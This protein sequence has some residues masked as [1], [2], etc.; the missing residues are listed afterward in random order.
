MTTDYL[1]GRVEAVQA[2]YF[3]SIHLLSVFD[4]RPVWSPKYGWLLV[5]AKKN[6]LYSAAGLAI[7]FSD[8]GELY[9]APLPFMQTPLPAERCLRK[10]ELAG[11]REEWVEPISQE[12]KLRDEL[13][14][15]YRVY[16]EFVENSAGN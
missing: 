5:N 1:L 13:R 6:Q 10:E 3:I 12:E 9:T 16:R 11:F 4:G 14:G 8:A 2:D 7:P 15:W